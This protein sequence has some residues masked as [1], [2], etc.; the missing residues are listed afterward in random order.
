MAAVREPA[1]VDVFLVVSGTRCEW[2]VGGGNVKALNWFPARSQLKAE[3]CTVAKV[4]HTKNAQRGSS[5]QPHC[6]QLIGCHL[7]V[8]T[9]H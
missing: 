1:A 5:I 4:I 7:R 8:K 9:I 2:P 3:M 6:R